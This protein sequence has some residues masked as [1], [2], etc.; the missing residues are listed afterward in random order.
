M[1]TQLKGF[2]RTQTLKTL[3]QKTKRLSANPPETAERNRESATQK[4]Y[5][6]KG[7]G[8]EILSSRAGALNT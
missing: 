7:Y 4:K 5:K 3:N 1:E 8:L 6:K 2:Q